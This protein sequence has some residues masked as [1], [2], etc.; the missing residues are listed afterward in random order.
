[1]A[2]K[3]TYQIKS[4]LY[5]PAVGIRGFR[6]VLA[7][8]EHFYEVDVPAENFDN[9]TLRYIRFRLMVCPHMDVRNLPR[10]V[11]HK[12]RAPLGRFLDFWI[13]EDRYGNSGNRKN[14]NA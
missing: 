3:Y 12:I 8:E 5:R 10:R 14:P 7:T 2:V 11:Q 1:M 4:V 9:E 6:V 13:L